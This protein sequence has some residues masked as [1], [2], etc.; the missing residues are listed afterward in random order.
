[1]T[2]KLSS[3]LQRIVDAERGHKNPWGSS[4]P[5]YIEFTSGSDTLANFRS[6]G[7]LLVPAVGQRI[8]LHGVVVRVTDVDTSYECTDRGQSS[9]FSTV[10]VEE[11]E[12]E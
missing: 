5:H 4:V 11:V 8:S 6:E 9:I 12:D 10:T 3:A 7:A 1:M 2:P